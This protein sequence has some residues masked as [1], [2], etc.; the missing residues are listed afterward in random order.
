MAQDGARPYAE[1]GFVRR[2]E[3]AAADTTP[4]NTDDDLVG[5]R[6]WL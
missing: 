2:V 6:A 1:R 4:V 5:G 3:I